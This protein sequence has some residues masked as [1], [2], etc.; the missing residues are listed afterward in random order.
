M[1]CGTYLHI[2]QDSIIFCQSNTYKQVFVF[3]LKDKELLR[4]VSPT[5]HFQPITPE[6]PETASLSAQLFYL[7]LIRMFLETIPYLCCYFSIYTF[8]DITFLY[9]I[10]LNYDLALL[11]HQ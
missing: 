3:F 5:S 9:P 4:N 7:V 6:S 1:L 8:L 11:Y 10:M 2:S